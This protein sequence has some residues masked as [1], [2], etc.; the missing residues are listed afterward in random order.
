MP[1][2][3]LGSPYEIRYLPSPNNINHSKAWDMDL[4]PGRDLLKALGM[5]TWRVFDFRMFILQLM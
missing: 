3:N 2:F 1:Q 4:F 5:V